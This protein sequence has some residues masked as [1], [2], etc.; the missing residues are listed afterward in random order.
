MDGK[1]NKQIRKGDKQMRQSNCCGAKVNDDSDIC[2]DCLEHC[3]VLILCDSCGEEIP[4]GTLSRIERG[5]IYC[6]PCYS[7]QS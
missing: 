2:L 5:Y 3:E 4:E 6:E 1:A 7:K